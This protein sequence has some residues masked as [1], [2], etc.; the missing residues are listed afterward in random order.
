LPCSRSSCPCCG[1]RRGHHPARRAL[2]AGVRTMVAVEDT[3]PRRASGAEG[4]GGRATCGSSATPS[5]RRPLVDDGRHRCHARARSR[6]PATTGP[7][8]S[9]LPRCRRATRCAH[10][11]GAHQDGRKHLARVRPGSR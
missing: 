7:A 3:R 10:C 6:R 11:R 5:A 4:T 1:A 8:R 9:W 2:S